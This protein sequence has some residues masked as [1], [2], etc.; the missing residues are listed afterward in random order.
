MKKGIIIAVIA[1]V[2]VI[3]VV[4]F[5]NKGGEEP[6]NVVTPD[7]PESITMNTLSATSAADLT[8]LVNRI[9]EGNQELFSSLATQ[10]IDVTDKDMVNSFT[11]LET[12]DA[13][14][15][16]VVSEPMMSSQAYSLVL[17]KVKDGEDVENIAK[18]MNESV[19][20]RKWICVCAEKVYTTT[21]GNI[22]C[23]VMSS[24]EMAKPVYTSFK[25]MAGTI[26][27]EY[28]RT[29]EEPEMEPDMY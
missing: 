2:C 10:E 21:S 25:S 28:E 9:Y 26:G 11:G 15:Y 14:E 19:N 22:V 24:E 1:L 17:A 5:M 7:V 12:G 3:C 16:L 4:C 18:T 6:E 27:E 13:L 20:E 23:L 8:D 29:V